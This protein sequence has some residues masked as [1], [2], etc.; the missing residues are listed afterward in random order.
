MGVSFD[1]V[2]F[3]KY[4]YRSSNGVCDDQFLKPLVKRS[5]RGYGIELLE[6]LL[7]F[8]FVVFGLFHMREVLQAA[9]QAIMRAVVQAR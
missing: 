5:A 9:C 4:G 6:N 2:D 1:L 8:L 3:A 7:L